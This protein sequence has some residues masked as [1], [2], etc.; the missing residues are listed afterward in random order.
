MQPL[1]PTGPTK[2]T[3]NA[4]HVFGIPVIAYTPLIGEIV[5][6]VSWPRHHIPT[7][8]EINDLS[9]KIAKV[10]DYCKLE[11]FFNENHCTISILTSH[12]GI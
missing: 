10:V 11:G 3:Q 7:E 1:P 5:M 4:F 8:E 9:G 12:P 2:L 6:P